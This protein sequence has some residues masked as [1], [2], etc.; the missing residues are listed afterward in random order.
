[1][2]PTKQQNVLLEH[3]QVLGVANVECAQR[4]PSVQTMD[5]HRTFS[6][7]TALMLMRKIWSH[8]NNVMQVPSAQVLECKLLKNAQ[9]EHTVTQLV[10]DIAFC[11]LR[12]TGGFM[13]HVP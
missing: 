7:Q 9:M 3:I 10:T 2:W 8:V 11:V 5:C 1:M 12:D 4:V 6:V 13:H